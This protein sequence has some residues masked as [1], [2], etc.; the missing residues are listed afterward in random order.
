MI[1]ARQ[2]DILRHALGINRGGS[3]N[4]FTADKLSRDF[5]DCVALESLGLMIRFSLENELC[6]GD[7]VFIVTKAGKLEAQK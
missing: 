3:R 2:K 5:Y 7:P 1:T 4:H 6:G